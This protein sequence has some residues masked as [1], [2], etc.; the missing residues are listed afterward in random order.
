MPFH[1][2]DDD[3]PVF[4]EELLVLDDEVLFPFWHSFRIDFFSKNFRPDGVSW[5]FSG[6]YLR[7]LIPCFE[8]LVFMLDVVA[9]RRLV[10]LQYDGLGIPR[11][12]FVLCP[13]FHAV[14]EHHL[15]TSAFRRIGRSR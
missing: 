10:C 14:L 6:D 1:P 11:P 7:E 4:I 12:I 15:W 2:V 13:N 5:K 8:P 3:L 9:G